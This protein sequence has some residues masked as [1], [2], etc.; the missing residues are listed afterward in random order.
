MGFEGGYKFEQD[1]LFLKLTSVEILCAIYLPSLGAL[2]VVPCWL[3][4]HTYVNHT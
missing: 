3:V 1:V 4:A 2:T